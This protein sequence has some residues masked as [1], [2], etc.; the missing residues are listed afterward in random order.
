MNTNDMPLVS[1]IVP[2]Y[3]VEKYLRR[4]VDSLLNQSYTNLEIILIDDGSPDNCGNI[5]DEYA[6]LDNRVVVIHKKNGGLSSARNA[7]IELSRGVYIGFIDSD[8]WV[9]PR[10]YEVLVRNMLR[11]D[12]D[13]SDISM[14]LVED[15]RP[16]D[17]KEEKITLLNNNDEILIDYFICDKCSVCRKIY[18]RTVIDDIR[19]P[20]GKINEDICTNFKFLQKTNVL[21]KSNLDLYHYFSNPLSITGTHFRERDFDLIDA[22]DELYQLAKN[23]PKIE[24]YARIKKAVSRYSLLGRYIA[25]TCDEIPNINCRIQEIYNELKD[26]FKLLIKSNISSKRKLL[27]IAICI[28]GPFRMKRIVYTI[29]KKLRKYR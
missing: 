15:E 24:P 27:I 1:V 21:V 20:E 25:Y 29:K 3:N 22:C 13:V 28:L 16:F 17:Y 23:N 11:S 10:M 5:C 4:C 12:A 18:S 14:R 8:D 6:L 19:F 2:I 26:N 7:G 9:E